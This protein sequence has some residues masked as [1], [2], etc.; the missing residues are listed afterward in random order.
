PDEQEEFK[1]RESNE[2]LWA[3]N[4]SAFDATPEEW[5]AVTQLRKEIED[6]KLHL[7]YTDLSG[8]DRQKESAKLDATLAESLKQT[9]GA[10]RYADYARANDAQF[11]SLYN[12]IQRYG[13]DKSVATEA[14]DL[15]QSAV[16]QADKLRNDTSLDPDVRQKALNLLQSDTEKALART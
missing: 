7:V 4:L 2:S 10:D 16:T 8:E 3:S 5:K 15:Q 14:Y 13:L 1:L 12:V 9:L 6:E 11:L